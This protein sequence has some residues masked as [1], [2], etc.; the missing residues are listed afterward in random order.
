[1]YRKMPARGYSTGQVLGKPRGIDLGFRNNDAGGT[2]LAALPC[3]RIGGVEGQTSP[4]RAAIWL[5]LAGVYLGWGTTYLANHYAL[6]AFPA[7]IMNGTRNLIA[8]VILY[9]F[10]RLRGARPPNGAMWKSALAVGFLM[11]CCGSGINVWAQGMTYSGIASL[12]VGST[13]LWMALF[14]VIL[15][16]RARQPGPGKMAVLGVLLGFGGIVLL[17]GPLRV[18]D[19]GT[20]VSPLGAAA[21]L[22][23]SFF[24]AAGSLKS[25]GAVFPPSRV[26]GSGMQMIGGGLCLIVTGLIIGEP[27]AFS[28]QRVTAHA[29]AGFAYLILIGSLFTFATYTWLLGVAPTPLVATYA[30]VNPVVAVILGVLILGEPVSLRLI[31]ASAMILAAV[32]VVTLSTTVKPRPSSR[33]RPGSG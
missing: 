28:F 17:V 25:R 16:A 9:A 8:G 29:A 19:A 32:A 13:P 27:A 1:M 5:G 11:L 33:S 6:E 4:G 3:G 7:F 10:Q 15:G 20:M 30:Y 18:M 21:L 14:D 12:L 2:W 31:V 23:G 26:L 24:W 22:T